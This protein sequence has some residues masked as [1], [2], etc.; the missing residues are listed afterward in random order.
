MLPECSYWSYWS[1]CSLAENSDAGSMFQSAD[2][3][4]WRKRNR[5]DHRS[6]D[7]DGAEAASSSDGAGRANEFTTRPKPLSAAMLVL[8]G[9]LA[10][11]LEIT[12]WVSL[13]LGNPGN[14]WFL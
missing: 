1:R 9:L 12:V 8:S 2:A 4:L 10:A 14:G 11:G 6:Q 5:S 3:D 13:K 7:E